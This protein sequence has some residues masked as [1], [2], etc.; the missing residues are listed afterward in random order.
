MKLD[1]SALCSSTKEV[2]RDDCYGSGVLSSP[3][4]VNATKGCGHDED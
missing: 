3:E 4:S 1:M 2:V